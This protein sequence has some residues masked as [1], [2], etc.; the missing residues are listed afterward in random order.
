M[1]Q[2][3]Y[4]DFYKFVAS[5][6]IALIAGAFAVPWL[7][8]RE[9]FDLTI[10]ESKVKTLT[11]I[12]RGAVMHRQQIVAGILPWLPW[13]SVL[14]ASLGFVLII[15]G[16]VM[17]STRQRVRD[18][19]EE[20]ATKKAE[21]ELRQMTEHEIKVKA[22]Q[23]LESVEE[24]SQQ[25]QVVAPVR[26]PV[27][28]LDAY[29]DAERALFARMNECLGPDVHIQTNQRVG[30]VEYDAIVRL[31]PDERV[32]VDVKY[33]RKGFNSGFLAET[34]N[35][36]TARTALYAS[37]FSAPSRAVLVIILASPNSIFVEKIENLKARLRTDRPQLASVGIHCITKDEI[38]ALTCQQVRQ[39]LVA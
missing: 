14:L 32:I 29:L 31:G 7:F 28:A 5:A 21:Q 35:G 26:V 3:E 19:G 22:V 10:D 37:R 6:G 24:E 1:A 34:V 17:W 39:M 13:A 30:N 11:P 25:P 33:I 9:P 16:L 8:L 36:L 23:E 27:S 2:L 12:A 20:A 18:R 38:P 4:G 15:C